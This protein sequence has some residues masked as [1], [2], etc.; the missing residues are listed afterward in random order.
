MKY[1]RVEEYRCINPRDFTDKVLEYGVPNQNGF[2]QWTGT[3]Q[4]KVLPLD[5]IAYLNMIMDAQPERVWTFGDFYMLTEM[6][7]CAAVSSYKNMLARESPNQKVLQQLE[8]IMSE[9]K[10]LY[11]KGQIKQFERT[12]HSKAPRGEWTLQLVKSTC[13]SQ[14]RYK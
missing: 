11:I 9:C 10:I 5:T 8:I 3:Y 13:T 14:C 6:R 12:H 1:Y 7:Y 4:N 2:I